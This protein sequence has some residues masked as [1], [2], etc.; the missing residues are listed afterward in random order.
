LLVKRTLSAILLIA[1][2]SSPLLLV[3]LSSEGSRARVLSC[4]DKL[5]MTG[6]NPF[7]LSLSKGAPPGRPLGATRKSQVH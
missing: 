2:P 4:F 5:S 7:T 6:T 3:I 1:L